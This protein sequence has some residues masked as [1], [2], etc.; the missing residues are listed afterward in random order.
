MVISYSPEHGP[1]MNDLAAIPAFARMV[2]LVK[3]YLR[4]SRQLLALL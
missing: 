2:A 3:L 4:V 1:V